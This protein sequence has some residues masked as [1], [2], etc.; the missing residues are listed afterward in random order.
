MARLNPTI[1]SHPLPK[2]PKC[3]LN[4]VSMKL[5]CLSLLKGCASMRALSQIHALIQISGLHRDGFI[6]S[7]VIRFCALS[8]SGNVDY[9]RCVLSCALDLTPLSWNLV[10]R[11]YSC[12]NKPREAVLVFHGMRARGPCPNKFTFPF[13]LKACSRTQDFEVGRQVQAEIVKNGIDSDVYV[14]NTLIHFYGSCEKIL[15]ARQVFDEMSFRTVVSW[16]AIITA[17]VENLCYDKS[18]STFRLMRNWKFEPDQ[19]TMVVLLSTCAELGNLRNGRLFHAQVIVSGFAVS[20]QLGTALVNMYAKCGDIDCA[21]RVFNIMPERNVWTWSAIIL[22][23]AQHGLAGEALLLFS[24]M[25]Q[26]SVEPNYV[27]Y[28]GV[29]SACTHAGLVDSGYRF[30]HDMVHVHKIEPMMSHYSAMVDIVSRSGHLEE[31]YKFITD[32]PVEAD[33]VVWRTL[34]GACAI[35]DAKNA[36]GVREK[37]RKRVLDLEP[38]R[39]E[40]YVVVSNMYAELGL[41]EEVAKVRK[42]MKEEG[43]KKMAGESSIEVEGLLHR[44]LCGDDSQMDYENIYYLLD[45]LILHM[46]CA[47]SR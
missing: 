34:L 9:A 19:T 47:A 20:D 15:H 46:K 11:G 25:K 26:Q 39:G 2:N 43:L 37:V 7:E 32:M 23:L 14:Q 42:V 17:Y 28:L 30:F 41:W 5:Q 33:G 4:M 24:H 27:T 31:A 29:L 18:L 1:S 38:T 21:Y 13:L 12:S 35:H 3:H 8:P 40:N 45:V 16:T 44:F 22:G 36:S 10:I 6:V